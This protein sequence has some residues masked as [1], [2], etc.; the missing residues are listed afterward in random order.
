MNDVACNPSGPVTITGPCR[1]SIIESGAQATDCGYHQEEFV[2]NPSGANATLTVS[3]DGVQR[4]VWT[5]NNYS[6][7]FGNTN[8]YFGMTASTGGS[9]NLQQAGLDTGSTVDGSTPVDTAAACANPTVTPNA[10]ATETGTP[11]NCGLTLPPT[12]TPTGPTNTFTQTYTF[13]KTPT[14]FPTPCGGRRPSQPGRSSLAARPGTAAI[15]PR[16]PTL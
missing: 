16:R 6:T 2:W 4:A 5:I 7:L 8:V 10:V 15:L 1:P 14:P 11:W 13:T 12:F 3:V 9:T